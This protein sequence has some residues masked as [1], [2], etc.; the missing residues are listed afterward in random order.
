MNLKGKK[1]LLRS[2]EE[3]DIENLRK[4]ANDP[5]YESMIVGWALPISKKDQKE[6]FS[7]YKISS[8]QLRLIIETE[9]DG[10]VGMTGLNAI[11]W[12]NGVAQAGGMR[13]IKKDLRTRG[14]ATDAYMTLFKY[15]FEELRLNRIEG[16]VLV[17]NI[18]S[19]KTTQK[20]GF[21]QEGIRREAV[22]KKGKYHDV[23]NLGIIKK[24]YLEK[25]QELGYE[26]E[27]LINE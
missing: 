11:D 17:Y 18:A 1:V 24:D 26:E 27:G 12:K 7:N 16:S 21:K 3:E 23:I 20:V 25:R 15:A 2:I 9:E 22:F 5:W 4:L 8:N 14:I 6:W 10:M 19:I 13:I